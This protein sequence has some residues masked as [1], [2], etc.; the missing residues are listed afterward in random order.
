MAFMEYPSKC[1]LWYVAIFLAS[2]LPMPLCIW[3]RQPRS[4]T[5]NT[6]IIYWHY[7]Q[8]WLDRFYYVCILYGL[9]Y[10]YMCSCRYELEQW[11]LN[12]HLIQFLWQ[13]LFSFFSLV[14]NNGEKKKK[15]E[16]KR[17]M[18]EWERKL[19]KNYHKVVIQI[20]FLYELC[21]WIDSLYITGHT[22]CLTIVD[23]FFLTTTFVF[24]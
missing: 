11:Y 3:S 23:H 9:K 21:L 1:F 6:M 19:S 7:I 2:F 16:N 22:L 17:V 14:K 10:Q 20:S 13:L 15:R 18:W 8:H 4:L 5:S 12:N 24:L